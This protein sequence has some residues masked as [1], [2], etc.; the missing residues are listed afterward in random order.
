MKEIFHSSTKT[1]NI[2]LF[3]AIIFAA[4]ILP[5]LPA[6]W[7]KG[8]FR[9]VY[10]IIYVAAIYS[11]NKRSNYLLALVAVTIVAEWVSGILGF[12][13]LLIISKCTNVVFFIVIVFRLIRQIA[14]AREVNAEIILGSIIGYLLIGIIYS[15]FIAIIIQKDPSA[16]NIAKA[17]LQIEPDV[18]D[19]STPLYFSYVTLATLGYGDLVP[20]KPYTRSLATWIAISG[21]FYIAILVALLVGKFT[22]RRESQ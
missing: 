7:H 12:E 22:V 15:I 16:F 3:S 10:T 20:L 19:I 9:V 5:V 17:G 11:L 13:L 8:L 1:W 21:Q 4:F 2:I 14:T 18:N 6:A